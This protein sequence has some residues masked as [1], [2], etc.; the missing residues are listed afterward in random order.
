[1]K[2]ALV[3][4]GAT[5]TGKT[6]LGLH[7]AKKFNGE[8]IACDSRQVYQGLDIGTGKLPSKKTTVKKHLGFW[9]TG[10]VTIWMYDVVNLHRQYSV[11]SYTE[12]VSAA[13][14][15][16]VEAGKLPIMVGGTG[17]Y[18]KALLEGLPNLKVPIDTKVRRKLEQKSKSDLQ[19]LLQKLSPVRWE[20]MN[21]SDRENPRRLVRSIE[22][23]MYPYTRTKQPQE[24]IL[25][26]FEVLKIGLTAP[27]N[28]LYQAVDLRVI[29]WIKDGI[30][31]EVKGLINSEVPLERFKAL[32]LEYALVA[33][34][35][36][37]EIKS[38]DLVKI[39]Q[40]KIHGF[41][42]RQQTWFKKEEGV[43][44]FDISKLKGWGEIEKLVSKWYDTPNKNYAS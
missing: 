4:L 22:L 25:K 2:K 11:S 40:Y 27:R 43:N 10:G 44:W 23:S 20:Q 15:K 5:A 17:L 8:L 32:G 37:G 29:Q 42:R 35:L 18:L 7:L 13:V 30:V 36:K 12:D 21:L 24:G 9:E 6:D 14:Q 3:I 28:Y 31:D 41:V 38:E 16:I 34:F 33:D 1:M 39:I 26:G 19:I